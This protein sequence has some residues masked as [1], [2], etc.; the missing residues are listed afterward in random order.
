[1][2][3]EDTPIPECAL[4][5]LWDREA[6]DVRRIAAQFANR[7]L[8]TRAASGCLG[9][10]DLQV[11]YVRNEGIRKEARVEDLSALHARFLE[12]YAVRCNDGWSS[13][14]RDGYYFEH[15]AWHLKE[16]GRT[17]EL[18]QLLCNFDWL[19]TK[20]EATDVNAL[21]ADYDYLPKEADLR[22]VQSVLRQSAH[23]LA[24]AARELAGQLIG[25]LLADKTPDIQRLLQ[26]A[27]ERKHW[28]WFRPMSRSLTEPGGPLIRTLQGHTDRVY[29]VAVTPDGRRAVSASGDRTLR[30]W[31]LESGQ[32]IR[33]LEGHT[34]SVNA[35]AVTLDGWRAVSASSDRT[36]RL[37]DL[38]SGQTLHAVQGHTG[39]VW[40]VAVTPD[41]RR[42]VSASEDQTLRLWD[43]ES[44]KEI[45][46]FTG[47][48]GMRSCAFTPDGCTI[49]AGDESGQV[50]FLQLVEADPTKPAPKDTKIQLLRREEP[51][52]D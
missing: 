43:L 34:G 14:P 29:A 5:V 47:E 7:S 50:H 13:G 30:L 40:A 36:L 17:E 6:K 24:R 44:A 41:G 11:D 27:T 51:A 38:E 26:Q 46:A 22:T 21:I 19:Q 18:K 33:T 15:L 35:V 20:L 48:S 39:Q 8:A 42:A 10:H 12:A 32:R 23:V 16:S 31:D 49:V 3:P 37:W 45:A 1:V 52:T 2:F 4:A 25:R 9:L 28:P